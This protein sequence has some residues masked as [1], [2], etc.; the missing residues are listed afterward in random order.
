[1]AV[2]IFE[3]MCVYLP[4]FYNIFIPQKE[5]LHPLSIALPPPYPPL[6]GKC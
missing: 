6:I 1:M 3:K 4:Q 5:T 2:S